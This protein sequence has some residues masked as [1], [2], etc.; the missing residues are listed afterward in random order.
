MLT[1]GPVEILIILSIG[2][3]AFGPVI[4]GLAIAWRRERLKN[5]ARERV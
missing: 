2:F 1:V 5:K 4:V 3:C